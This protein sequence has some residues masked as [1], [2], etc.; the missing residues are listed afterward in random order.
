MGMF[1]DGSPGAIGRQRAMTLQAH[2]AARLDDVRVVLRAM[3]VVTAEAKH[4]ALMH[5]AGY[6]IVALHAVLVSGVLGIMREGSLAQLVLFKSPNIAQPLAG[7]VSHG[8]IVIAS[9]DGSG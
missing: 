3:D 6:K 1:F 2:E 7:F 8:P 5:P 9:V 4:T